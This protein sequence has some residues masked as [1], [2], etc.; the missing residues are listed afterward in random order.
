MKTINRRLQKLEK[1][2][3]KQRF[4][5][6]FGPVWSAAEASLSAA[7][8]KLLRAPNY[9]DVKVNHPEVWQRFDDALVKASQES[10]TCFSMRASYLLLL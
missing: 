5:N 7:D 4:I 8:R 2:A 10:G 1:T 3:A 9:R 6:P